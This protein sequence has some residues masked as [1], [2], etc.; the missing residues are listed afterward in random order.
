MVQRNANVV[1]TRARPTAV[2]SA[3]PALNLDR[4]LNP[5]LTRNLRLTLLSRLA[6]AIVSSIVLTHQCSSD[7]LTSGSYT[8]E[9]VR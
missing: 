5:L 1:K 6:L 7:R 4:A 2:T 8:R 9:R 3:D